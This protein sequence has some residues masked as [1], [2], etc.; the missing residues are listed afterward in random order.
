MFSPPPFLLYFCRLLLYNL[1]MKIA[2]KWKDYQVLATGDGM[3]LERWGNVVLLRPD[4]QVI[5]R[6][7]RDLYACKDLNA[8]YHRSGKGGGGWEYLK[9][10][11][12]EWNISYRDLKFVVKPMGLPHTRLLPEAAANRDPL[13]PLP[14]RRTRPA[15]S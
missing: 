6:A 12:E 14:A 13:P 1:P 5:W 8:V 9:P 2:D 15:L 7:S 3:K 10:V 11:P 4:P